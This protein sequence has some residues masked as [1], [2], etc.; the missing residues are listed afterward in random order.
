MPEKTS[1]K[2]SP[3]AFAETAPMSLPM[4][5]AGDPQYADTVPSP[6]TP[7]PAKRPFDEMSLSLA[8]VEATLYET[9]ALLR[10]E[11]RVCPQPT[12]WLEFYRILQD[13]RVTPL[14][15][16]PLTGSAWAATPAMAKRQ[17]FLEQV[18]WADRNGCLPQVHEFLQAL[19][20]SDWFCQ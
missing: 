3:S 7:V 19:P 2:I 14:P 12:R 16:S 8:P 20:S 15:S 18:E 4:E 17:C 13:S 6:L 5:T 11:D 9:M 1:L 10:K